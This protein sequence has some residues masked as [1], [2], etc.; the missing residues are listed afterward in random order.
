MLPLTHSTRENP[1]RQK[2]HWPAETL[3]HIR[4]HS[5]VFIHGAPRAAPGGSGWRKPAV[6]V[7]RI[8]RAKRSRTFATIRM[9]PPRAAP[10]AAGVSQP[11]RT[12]RSC[13]VNVITRRRPV[14]I[15]GA[16]A[17]PRRANARRSCKRAFVYRTSRS[18]VGKCP[19]HRTTKSGGR[20]PPV[21]CEH[22]RSATN[23]RCLPAR[24]PNHRGLTVAALVNERSCIAQVA[25]SSANV[26]TTEPPRAGGVSPTWHVSILVRQETLGAAGAIPVPR[27]ADARRS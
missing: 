7:K 27:R 3:P 1:A 12:V 22:P 26:R 19:H 5:R 23:A 8:A 6:V 13:V 14:A 20:K 4:N 25:V 17:E 21:A 11:W 24:F 15:T 9:R 10:G 16:I 2:T 18:F